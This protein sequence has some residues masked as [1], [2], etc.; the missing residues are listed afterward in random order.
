MVKS[1]FSLLPELPL[2]D[3]WERVVTKYRVLGKNTHDAR[4]VAAM[5]VHGIENLLTFNVQDFKRYPDIS[6]LDPDVLSRN[7]P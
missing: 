3:E 2:L 5:K 4:L 7:A 1:L 6:V